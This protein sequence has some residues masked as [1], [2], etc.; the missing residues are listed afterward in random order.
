[1]S[2]SVSSSGAAAARLG[3]IQSHLQHPNAVFP[4]ATA[5]PAPAPAPAPVPAL[6]E[7][8]PEKVAEFRRKYGYAKSN[9]FQMQGLN[10]LALVSSDMER[11]VTFFGDILGLRLS[12]TIDLPDGGQ[13]FFFD[14]GNGESLA[15]FWFPKAPKSVPGVSSVDPES[16]MSGSFETAHGSMNHVAFNVPEDKIRE[17]RKRLVVAGVKCSPVVYHADVP[18]GFSP[19]KDETTS[20]VSCYFFGPDGEYLE[21]ASQ[22]R[23]FTPEVD[24]GHLPRTAKDA[25]E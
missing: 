16:L 22:V 9:A 12:K 13:H 8:P 5:S 21:I 15:Y 19:T 10:H 4:T 1:M 18:H 24:I 20:F 14:I 17:Y 25:L 11:T 2:S 23:T 6:Q 7:Y 3:A